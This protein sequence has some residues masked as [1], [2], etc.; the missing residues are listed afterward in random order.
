MVVAY[1]GLG[2]NLNAPLLQLKK[3]IHFIANSKQVKLLQTS[4]F[5]LSKPLGPQDQ[6]DFVNAVMGIETS[7]TAAALLT[8]CQAI[9]EKLGRVRKQHWGPRII[10]LD[11]LLF[12]NQKLDQL[13][14]TVPHPGLVQREFVIYPLLEIAPNLILPDGMPLQKQ[15]KS[16]A[17]NGLRKLAK[18]EW[19]VACNV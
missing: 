12:G 16:V 2:S 7:L 13:E 14:L 19:E 8:Q 18:D 1:I 17:L 9:E 4:S 11:I 10:D 6:P 5:Y 15:T 3:A